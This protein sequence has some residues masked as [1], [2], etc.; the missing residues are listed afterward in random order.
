MLTTRMRVILKKL[1]LVDSPLT[2]RFLANLNKV[3]TRTIREDIKKLDD[4]VKKHGAEIE[5]VISK[6][7][8]LTIYN[9]EYFR[10]FLKDVVKNERK[11][12]QIIYHLPQDREEYIIRRLSTSKG[13]VKLEQLA[14]EL[15]VSKSTV[16]NDLKQVKEI[17]KEYSITVQSRPNYGLK[18]QGEE[19]KLRFCMAEYIVE[20][21]K[22]TEKQTFHS[23]L[24]SRHKK[25]FTIIHN[26]IIEHIIFHN[27]S[28]SDI[29]IN[30]LL[31]HIVIAYERIKNGNY[32]VFPSNELR[33]IVNQ[34]EFAVAKKIVEDVETQ[35]HIQFP[36]VETA[37]IAIHLLGTKMLFKPNHHDVLNEKLIAS[38]ILIIVKKMLEKI[39]DEYH[40]GIKYD[41]ELIIALGLHLKPAINRY[42]YGMNI[43][44]PLLQDIKKKYPLAFEAAILAGLVIEEMTECKINENELGYI[45]LHIGAAMERKSFNIEPKRCLI[46]CA[47]GFGTAQLI[48]YKIKSEFRDSLHIVGITE[49]YRIKKYNSNDID[50]IISS[51]PIE[52]EISIPVVQVNAIIG[53][54]DIQKISNFVKDQQ[55]I[56]EYFQKQ[57]VFL[58]KNLT[59]KTEVL[60][61]LFQQL[62]IFELVDNDY[63]EYVYKREK[64]AST[65]YGNLV[66]IPH[67]VTPQ[68]DETFLTV[69]TLTNV[70]DWG[71]KPAQFI[72][73]LN[74]KRN[75]QED[76]QPMY[77]L[78]GAIVNS[79]TIVQ[80]LLKAN[81]YASFIKVLNDY[82]K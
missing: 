62:K 29:S 78:L 63:L 27:I 11:K 37:Y 23:M 64:I 6:G 22:N 53:D 24:V 47:S 58:Q 81:D 13:Y 18:L 49:L 40:L 32:V 20:R 39:D 26:I 45:A 82:N 10:E 36:D 25:A 14:D 28:M 59:T 77:D 60:E 76:L 56:M 33:Q 67:P 66:A 21:D 71:D 68:T 17:L 74:V 70:I 50:L 38:D 42:K 80:Q 34:Y 75:S 16:Q 4:L 12:G 2:G 43:R 46:V 35:L 3:T 52:A 9:R 19:L 8:K 69:C 65:V 79:E 72:C 30:N 55:S 5:T 61:F 51:V 41:K 31:I 1:M 44:N 48:Y 57:F 54:S 15:Y 73:L 7:Y